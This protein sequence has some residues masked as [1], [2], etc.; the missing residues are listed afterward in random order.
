MSAIAHAD[1]DPLHPAV[2][3]DPYPFYAWLREHDPVK[4]VPGVGAWAVSRHEDVRALLLDHERFSS[5]PLIRIAFGEFNPAP[6]ARY[7]ISS[8]PPDH[9][10]LRTL[11]NKAFSRRYVQDL[12]DEIAATVV[13]LLEGLADRE[14]FDFIAE[15][16]APLPVTVVGNILGVEPSMHA[17][18]RRWSNNVTAGGNDQALTPDQ[19]SAM[20]SD[21]NDFRA[22][23]LERIAAVRRKPED[24]LISAL[25]HAEEAGQ[26]LSAD[27]VLA[28]SVLLLIA[29]NETTTNLLS[30][31]LLTMSQFPA[32]TALARQ[33]RAL[34]PQLIDESLR[35]LSP[36][37]LLFR[38]ATE[39]T[40]IA[41]VKLAKDSIVM[42]IFASANR[43]ERAFEAPERMNIRRSDLRN[44]LAFGWGIHMCVGK[45]LANAEGELALNALFDRYA[46]IDIA[47][48][49]IEW[50]DAFYLRGPKTLPVRVRRA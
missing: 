32:E 2:R 6:D 23:F 12:R 17:S 28:L 49:A 26:H 25:V 36:I 31:G 30:N 43:D 13:Q 22:Y 19:R 1:Y 16:A 24:N 20:R 40:E 41:G 46:A 4:F 47:T 35:F 14:E 15:F 11:V 9:L 48:P 5:D 50:C 3:E 8:D 29:G 45:A 33:E 34:V 37:Q 39:D 42:P 18:F 7:L 10:R 27:E 21:A 38:R 44:Q